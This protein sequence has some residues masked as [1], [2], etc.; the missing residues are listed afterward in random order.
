MNRVQCDESEKKEYN[1]KKIREQHR[2]A[3]DYIAYHGGRSQIQ[4]SQEDV[5]AYGRW[6]NFKRR[7]MQE[8]DN[9]RR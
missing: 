6:E 5:I 9:L 1:R 7:V 8:N 4:P 3:S 2:H